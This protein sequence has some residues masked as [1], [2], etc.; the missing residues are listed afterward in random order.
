MSHP[1][2]KPCVGERER[3][4]LTATVLVQTAV[5]RRGL[6]IRR[7]SVPSP[8]IPSQAYFMSTPLVLPCRWKHETSTTRGPE[9]DA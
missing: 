1:G 7:Q 2:D 8:W 3:V 5:Y 6:A 4:C 9:R